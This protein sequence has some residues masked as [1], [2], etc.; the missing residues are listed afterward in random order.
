[1]AI[2]LEN[3]KIDPQDV[4]IGEDKNQIQTIKCLGDVSSSLQNKYFTFH[5][6]SGNKHAAW[7]NVATLGVAPTISGHTLHAVAIGTNDSSFAVAAALQGI[8]NAV[9]GFTASV[10][11]ALVTLAVTADGYAI[12]A[13]DSYVSGNK[14]NFTFKVSQVGQLETIVGCLDG[15]IELSGFENEIEEIKCHQTGGTVQAE[16][17]KGYGKPELSLTLKETNKATIQE[18]FKYAGMNSILVPGAGNEEVFGYGPAN[19]GGANP[20]FKIRMHPRRLP[21]TDFSED[22][23]IWKASLNLDTFT[24]SG[25][26]FS[27]IPM[28]WSIYPDESKPKQIQF[29]MIGD[30][31]NLA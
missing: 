10:S 13:A 7:F 25:E 28:N 30:A 20:L 24:W 31:G 29:F 3:I 26:E 6:E 27:S 12:P 8:L 18:V 16:V 19:L 2:N 15:N 22:M 4:Y 1:M 17:I 23:H 11:G 5:D 14:T 9:S 21:S